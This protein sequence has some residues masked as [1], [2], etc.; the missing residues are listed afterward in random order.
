MFF[1]DEPKHL[2]NPV[3]DIVIFDTPFLEF[4]T[5]TPWWYVP[6]TFIPLVTY[7]TLLSEATPMNTAF[8]FLLG[9]FFWTLFEYVT[10]RF[11]F[12]GEDKYLA[13]SSVAYAFH[14]LIHGIHHAFPQDKNRLVFPPILALPIYH[15][16]FKSLFLSLPDFMN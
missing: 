16:I 9:L 4:F 13:Q 8:Y 7:H 14:F 2:I 10:H 5:R 15:F 3:R 11:A 12:H 6:M 1:I